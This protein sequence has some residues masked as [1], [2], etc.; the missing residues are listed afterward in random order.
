M[1]LI[2]LTN[3][4]NKE[5]RKV[6]TMEKNGDI[7]S[8]VSKDSAIKLKDWKKTPAINGRVATTD[9]VKTGIAVFTIEKG[10]SKHKFYKMQLPRLAYLIDSE[11]KDKELV[12]VIQIEST[13]KD[14]VAGYR[15]ID[16]TS[17]ACLLYELEF[18]DKEAEEKIIHLK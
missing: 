9:D 1:F 7:N 13:N 12:I 6:E 11:T 2:P 14:T 10:G 16:G 8:Q 18:I 15:S 5:P 17:G 3:C 4:V